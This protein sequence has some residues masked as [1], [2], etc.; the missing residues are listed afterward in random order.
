MRARLVFL[1]IVALAAAIGMVFHG[2]IQ[3]PAEY[4]AFA[5]QATMF[6][7][8]NFWNVV[9][10]APLALVGGWGLFI[11]ARRRGILPRP[12]GLLPPLRGAYFCLFAGI[13]LVGFGSAYYHLHPDNATIVWDRLP[14]AVAFMAILAIA[15]GEHIGVRWGARLLAPLAIL[16]AG[17]VLYWHWTG[18]LRPYLL[19]Q[20]LTLLEIF[21][22]LL[23]FRS[24]LRPVS[25]FWLALG[26]YGV[27]KVFELL[28]VSIYH[29]LDPVSGHPL[30]HLAAAISISM[31]VLAVKYR[32]PVESG[33]GIESPHFLGDI[34][35]HPD[36]LPDHPRQYAQSR[37]ERDEKHQQ[38]AGL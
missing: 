4:H 12:P 31:L 27:A 13:F 36:G 33:F 11:L 15:V 37:H 28:D 29:T 22:I 10:N 32:R 38:R 7:V 26:S 34:V 20:F 23:L 35:V 25:Y 17:S 6:G 1:L 21:L 24:A 16:G 3:Q 2:P 14:L 19:V 8:P 9:S 30:K 5:D 18:D